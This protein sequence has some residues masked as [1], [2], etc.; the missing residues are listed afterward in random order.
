MLTVSAAQ[1]YFLFNSGVLLLP[2]RSAACVAPLSAASSLA[3]KIMRDDA[4]LQLGLVMVLVE[5]KHRFDAQLQGGGGAAVAVPRTAR[6]G[7]P[8]QRG[9]SGSQAVQVRGLLDSCRT[10]SAA[11]R[12][13]ACIVKSAAAAS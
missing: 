13:C 2:P 6:S 5:A 11:G 1:L 3:G 10:P 8:S 4:V 7:R 9:G 12:T